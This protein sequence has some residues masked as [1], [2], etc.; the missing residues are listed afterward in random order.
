VVSSRVGDER[1][2]LGQSNAYRLPIGTE[3]PQRDP[4]KSTPLIAGHS[5][6]GN[7]PGGESD[8]GQLPSRACHS[9]RMR[10]SQPGSSRQSP[11]QH[12]GNQLRTLDIASGKAA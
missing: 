3:A 8:K 7:S 2:R 12:L 10:T 6:P 9:T 4:V 5:G 11:D 1:Q